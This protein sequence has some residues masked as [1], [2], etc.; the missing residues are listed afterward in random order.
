M[1]TL[2]YDF[3]LVYD[4]PYFTQAL[5]HVIQERKYLII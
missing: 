3:I 1:I 2:N 4:K 5:K